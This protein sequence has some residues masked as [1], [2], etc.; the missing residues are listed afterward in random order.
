MQAVDSSKPMMVTGATGYVAGSVIELL[1]EKGL[2]VHAAV[3]DSQNTEKLKYLNM[4]AEKLPGSIVYFESD[5]LKEG[6]YDEAMKG[7]SVVFHTASP[8]TLHPS[9]PQLDLVDPA[10][11]GTQNVLDAVNRT[12]SVQRVVLTSSVA[13]I[14]CDNTD[15][16]KTEQGCF[17]E[18]NWNTGASLDHSPY[19]FSKV[20]AEKKAW[21]IADAQDRWDLVTINPSL[22]IGPGI[23]PYATSESFDIVKQMGDGTLKSGIPKMGLGAVDVRDVATAHV[24]A[25]FTPTA[26]GRYIVSGYNTNMLELA[27]LLLP[28]YGNDF[29]IPKKSLPKWVVWLLGPLMDKS[30]TRKIISRNVN[31]PFKADNSKGIKELGLTYR[32]L[33]E[34]MNAFFQ[35]MV[36]AGYFKK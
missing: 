2:T 3:R 1:L 15:L 35:Q 8:F 24:K 27:Q 36:D 17:T 32:P 10:L 5:L 16:E 34:S 22:V 11:L 13:A 14:F 19:F 28:K 18:A 29:P 12:E 31:K 25:A 33:A 4:L 7:C 26:K 23:N 6:S 21:S 9:D 30:V 20:L